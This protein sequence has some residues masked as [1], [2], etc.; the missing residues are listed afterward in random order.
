VGRRFWRG[1][2]SFFPPEQSPIAPQGVEE[3]EAESVLADLKRTACH[4]PLAQLQ[5][6]AAYFLFGELIGSAPVMCR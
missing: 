2:A 1:T 4:A 5:E 6:I 3:E